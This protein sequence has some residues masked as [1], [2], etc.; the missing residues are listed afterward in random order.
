MSKKYSGEKCEKQGVYT[1]VSDRTGKSPSSPERFV[2]LGDP[3]PPSE[4]NHHF[5][6]TRPKN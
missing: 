4:N 6:F 1:Q 3:F 2:K 5:V